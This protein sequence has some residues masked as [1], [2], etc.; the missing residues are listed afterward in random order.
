MGTYVP[1]FAIADDDLRHEVVLEQC[2]ACPVV[3]APVRAWHA[4]LTTRT[5][6]H[7]GYTSGYTPEENTY[8]AY[9]VTCGVEVQSGFGT[10]KHLVLQVGN[11][12]KLVPQDEVVRIEPHVDAAE[13][14]R[15]KNKIKE[16][17]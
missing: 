12:W 11:T 10:K 8:E 14:E 4:S 17:V 13:V 1:P 6:R 9:I 16:G 2:K 7:S 3:G 15:I 5:V